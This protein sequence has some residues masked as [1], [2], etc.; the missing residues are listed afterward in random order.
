MPFHTTPNFHFHPTYARQ[1]SAF[2]LM[3]YIRSRCAP[4]DRSPEDYVDPHSIPSWQVAQLL[5]EAYFHS[6]QGSFRFIEREQFLRALWH[7]YDHATITTALDWSQRRTLALANVMWAIGAKWM[8]MTRPG[9]QNLYENEGSPLIEN[10]LMHYA[11]ARAL[12][13]DHRVQ[14]DHPNLEMV[15]GMALLS[16]YLLS[17]GSIHRSVSQHPSVLVVH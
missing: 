6:I 3:H 4:D 9:L 2:D 17:N 14:V 5:T 12:G 7:I 15:E 10:Q 13:L 8:E 11:R 16:F 1:P